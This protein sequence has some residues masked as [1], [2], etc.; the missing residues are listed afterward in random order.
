MEIRAL[1]PAG[2]L[3]GTYL[4][5]VL[6]GPEASWAAP[7]AVG[8]VADGAPPGPVQVSLLRVREAHADLVAGTLLLRGEALGTSPDTTPTVTLSN[9]PLTVLSATEVEVLAQLPGALEAG[10]YRLRVVRTAPGGTASIWTDAMDVTTV[11]GVG[12]GDITAVNTPAGGG[13]QGGVTS[14]DASLSLLSCGLDQVLKSDGSTWSCAADS[15]TDTGVNAV[16]GGG[17]VTGV[18]ETRTLTL[19]ST[20][21]PTNT[22]GAI[23]ARD[24]TGSFSAGS[25]GLAGNLDL[26][27]TASATVGVLTKGG[28]PFLHNSGLLNTFVG[29]ATGNF[30]LTG[31]S[32]SAF[33]YAALSSSTTGSYNSA[34][35]DRALHFNSTGANN[36]AFGWGALS[37]NTTGYENSAFGFQAL[38]AN[39]TGAVNSAFGYAALQSNTTGT[40]NSAFGWGALSANT[41]A[42]GSSAFGDQA[43]SFNSS[44]ANNSAFGFQ[45]L[46]ANTTA[47]GSSAFGYQA[48]SANTT[49]SGSS[50]FGYQALSANTTGGSNSAFGNGALSNLSIGSGN[51]ALGWQAGSNL[52]SGNYNIYIGNLGST[53]SEAGTIRIGESQTATY[54]AGIYSATATT[55]AVYVGPD[56]HL[57][58]LSSSRRYK[59]QIAD[60]DAES[61]VLLKLRPVSFYYRPELDGTHVRQHGLVAEEVAEVAPGLVDY[62]EDGQPQTVRY[63]LV[64]AMLLNEV[65]KQRRRL[66]AQDALIQD[67]QDHLAQLEARLP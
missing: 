43:L 40:N 44:G 66:E 47:S 51:L 57:G 65:Q 9:V 8:D 23:V 50:A 42:S 27:N 10:S 25:V 53:V 46:S 3:P 67:L 31:Q 64:N 49:A 17:G 34:F 33:G 28:T 21:T 7:V 13:L 4:L 30:V 39:T 45:A 63:H 58:T 15:D 20:A 6:A 60:M 55:K 29:A 61:D 1:L 56:G 48:L 12:K 36:S 2:I 18:I 5:E 59:E 54:I 32:N 35:G 38:R 52:T 19:G 41:T 14:G 16:V 11:A 37:A 62:G 26:P 24:G 22:A